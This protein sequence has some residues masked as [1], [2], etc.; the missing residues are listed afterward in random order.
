MSNEQVNM[1]SLLLT[2]YIMF[3]DRCVKS[4]SPVH[5]DKIKAFFLILWLFFVIYFIIH[6]LIISELV[7]IYE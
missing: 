7:N 1:K 5:F 3:C 6:S 2:Q 4:S